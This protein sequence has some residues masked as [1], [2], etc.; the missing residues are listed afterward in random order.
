MAKSAKWRS[1]FSL[2]VNLERRKMTSFHVFIL[3]GAQEPLVRLAPTKTLTIG[4]A[5]VPAGTPWAPSCAAWVPTGTSI[6]NPVSLAHRLSDAFDAITNGQQTL[7]NEMS[8]MTSQVCVCVC[9]H[10]ILGQMLNF[11]EFFPVN[12]VIYSSVCIFA[13]QSELRHLQST[14]SVCVCLHL[15]WVKCSIWVS[16]SW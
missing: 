13:S 7:K 2:Q 1:R 14:V 5:N 8:N 16:F 9:L 3:Q 12:P 15:I 4:C 10:L 6:F 11:G